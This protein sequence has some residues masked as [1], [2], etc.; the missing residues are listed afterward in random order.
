MAG[1]T[2]RCPTTSSTS[3]FGRSRSGSAHFRLPGSAV[4]AC[5]NGISLAPIEDFRRDS[6]LFARGSAEHRN[7]GRLKNAMKRGLQTRDGELDLAKTLPQLGAD[8][9]AASVAS[10]NS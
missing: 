8:G 2:A 3:S 9:R 4:K 7:Q 10:S 1:S 6:D 5:V